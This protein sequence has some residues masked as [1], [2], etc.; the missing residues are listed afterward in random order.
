MQRFLSVRPFPAPAVPCR[1]SFRFVS[2]ARASDGAVNHSALRLANPRFRRNPSLAPLTRSTLLALT[3]AICYSSAAAQDATSSAAS[4]NAPITLPTVIVEGRADS[5]VGLADS[6]AQGVVGAEQLARRPKLR[7]GEV[8]ETVPGLI[9]TQHSGAG[10]ANQYFLRGFNLDH[11]TDFAT[12]FEGMPINLPTHGHGQG[13]TDLNWMIPEFIKTVTYR[14]GPYYADVGDFGAAGAA[15]I[16]YIRELPGV[17]TQVEGGSYG[18]GRGVFGWSPKMKDGALLLGGEVFHYDGPWENPDDYWRFNGLARYSRG[19]DAQ[20]W[21]VTGLA[22]HGDWT[23]TDQIAR[24]AVTSGAVGRFGTLDPTTGGQ[25]QRYSLIGEWHRDDGDSATRATAYTYYYD[26]DLFSNFTYFLGSPLG[27]QFEQLDRRWA[28][29][30]NAAHT[31][32]GEWLGAEMEN[33]VGVQFRHDAIH[34]GLFQTVGRVR[35]DKPDYDGGT[36]RATTREDHV[37]QT[38]IGPWF[39]NRARWN[40]W[41]RSTA[42]VRLD[43]Y[44]FDV[45]SNLAANSGRTDDVIAS[46]KLGLVFGPW[47]KT[48]FYAN[49]GL[50]FH[51]NDG[52]GATTTIDPATGDPVSPVD[53]LVQTYGAEIGARTTWLPGLQSTLSLW[54]LDLD[55][56]LLFIGDAGTTEA[57]RPSRRFGV[58]FANYYQPTDWLTL[59]ADFSLSHA[60]FR[61]DDPAGRHIPGSIESAIAAGVSVQNLAGGLFGE[62]RVRFFGP[63]PLIEDNSVRSGESTLVN[64]RIGWRFNERWTLAAEVY[65]LFDARVSDIDYFYPSR[66]AGEPAGPDDGGFNDVHFHPAE[67]RTFRVVLTARF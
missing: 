42:G 1:D 20:G 23:A 49:A 44:H 19:D 67:R 56:E 22:Y 55:S 59:D 45:D 37:H 61:D 51:S 60:R 41:L 11:G 18:Y 40:D 34:N 27:D 47:A 9:A 53:A 28:G 8:L 62:L 2:N 12:S 36:I 32:R 39:E 43:Y 64:G 54:W 52:R 57:S 46:P 31:Q 48:E 24:R 58:E 26:L 4:T 17:F 35:T 13:Y 6:A 14:K 66:L 29:G 65:N 16:E 25:S 38:S 33:T 50:G 3:A 21:S 63:R 15:D 10:K 7:P 30:L 5:L